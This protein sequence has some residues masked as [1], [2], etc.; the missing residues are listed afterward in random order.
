MKIIKI[1]RN[2]GND[3]VIDDMTVS[4]EHARIT[5]T[6]SG[7][8]S[9]R[10]LNSKNGTYVNG[11]QIS[12]ETAISATDEIKV[13]NSIVDWMRFFHKNAVSNSN[14]TVLNNKLNNSKSIGRAP[15]N[16]IVLSYS[17]VSSKHAIIRKDQSG[18]VILQD[19]NSTNGTFVN[20]NKIDSYILKPG[21]KVLLA[22]K[23][24]LEWETI[25]GVSGN[26]ISKSTTS[27][28]LFKPIV[29][30][31]V[32]VAVICLGIFFFVK[33][34]TPVIQQQVQLS[35]EKIYS[36]YKKSVVMIYGTYYYEVS[37]KGKI[38]ANITVA[39]NQLAQYNGDNPITY[40]ATG[41]FVSKD[42]KIM[43]NRHVVCPWD[44]DDGITD[45]VKEYFQKYLAR[46]SLSNQKAFMA[47]Q[48]MIGDVVV[49]G[50]LGKLFGI[51]LNDSFVKGINDM[52]PCSYIRDSGSKNIDLGLLQVNSKSLPAGVNKI[53]DL[54]LADVSA[55]A[56]QIG[57]KVFAIGFPAGFTVGNTNTGI[58]ANNQS[59]EITQSRGD[60]EFG[61]NISITHG[62]SGS[63]IFNSYGQLV[64]IVNAGFLG[65]AQGYNMAVKAKCAVEL[66]N[67]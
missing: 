4:S 5:I 42:G 65:V 56:T 45:K 8:V 44:Y 61:H 37:A 59:G 57:K 9:I 16:D 22:N 11:K 12:K 31:V 30:A 47:L 20:N 64:G 62:A 58:E 24:L 38:L 53:V 27:P 48:P 40:T 10:D 49:Q 46:L 35:P 18:N 33:L 39:D 32:S 25:F 2:P 60:V 29:I 55:S 3:I 26:S 23:Y 19:N 1:G 54:S 7:S 34:S 21:D 43:T 63:P 13:A 14:H 28:K 17:D 66:M 67:K 50:K 41:F 51:F 6:D 15:E 52:I 36:I